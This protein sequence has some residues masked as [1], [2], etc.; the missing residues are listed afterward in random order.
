MGL[1][2]EGPIA[3]ATSLLIQRMKLYRTSSGSLSMWD[4]VDLS[5]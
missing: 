1:T 5:W 2:R 4:P 3:V